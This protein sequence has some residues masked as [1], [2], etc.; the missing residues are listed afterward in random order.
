[1]KQNCSFYAHC[2]LYTHW[3]FIEYLVPEVLLDH[4]GL[5]LTKLAFFL[6]LRSPDHKKSTFNNMKCSLS[7]SATCLADLL[8][9]CTADVSLRNNG[10]CHFI[11]L[12]FGC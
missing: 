9:I 4:C 12:S 2:F 10:V 7:Y 11:C 6:R 3:C 8:F 5:G 1:M